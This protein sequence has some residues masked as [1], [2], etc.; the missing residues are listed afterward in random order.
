MNEA[1]ANKIYNT[2][3]AEGRNM[4]RVDFVKELTGMTDPVKMA[5]DIATIQRRK[6]TSI[7]NR[8]IGRG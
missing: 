4:S 1:Q 8:I 5:A 6:Q 7:V 2:F 3:S